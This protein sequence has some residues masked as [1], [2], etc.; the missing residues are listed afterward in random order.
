MFETQLWAEIGISR[1]V[2]VQ[3]TQGWLFSTISTLKRSYVA[4]QQFEAKPQFKFFHILM[5]TLLNLLL[6]YNS[7][8]H[9]IFLDPLLMVSFILFN[10][11]IYFLYTMVYHKVFIW[12]PF[13]I[14]YSPWGPLIFFLQFIQADRPPYVTPLAWR[15][16]VSLLHRS[17]W[18]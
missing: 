6:C 16:I 11:L 17:V 10:N 8:S 7:L 18:S 14:T 15:S 13:S 4:Q 9:L 5:Q 12:I 1:I 2:I 3:C